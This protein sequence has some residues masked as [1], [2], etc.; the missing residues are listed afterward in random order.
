MNESLFYPA[1][2][3][4]LSEYMNIYCNIHV[5]I[6]PTLQFKNKGLPI[7]TVLTVSLVL[8][9]HGDVTTDTFVS[10]TIVLDKLDKALESVLC[11]V[12]KIRLNPPLSLGFPFLLLL[13]SLLFRRMFMTSNMTLS[14][15][16]ES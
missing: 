3:I 6:Y 1:A 10:Y 8:V 7:S 12:I 13:L 9:N 2:C 5:I 4:T 16:I 11:V 15:A 14:S